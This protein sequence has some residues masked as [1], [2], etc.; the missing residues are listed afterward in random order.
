MILS[1]DSGPIDQDASVTDNSTHGT[2]AMLVDLDKLLRLGRFLQLG[3][4]LFL[5]SKNNALLRFDAD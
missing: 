5:N 2:S 4:N 1:L 3:H